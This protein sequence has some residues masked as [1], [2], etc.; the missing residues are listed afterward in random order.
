M[1]QALL[2]LLQ[3]PEEDNENSLSTLDTTS[4]KSV[5]PLQHKKKSSLSS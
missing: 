3:V 2:N 5:C 1:V 4:Y